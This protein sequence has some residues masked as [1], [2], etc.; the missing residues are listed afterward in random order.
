MSG[1]RRFRRIPVEVQAMRWP[2]STPTT[3]EMRGKVDDIVKWVTG[4]G[5]SITVDFDRTGGVIRRDTSGAGS[6]FGLGDYIVRDPDG[7]FSRWHRPEFRQNY[8]AVPS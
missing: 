8:E 6:R 5:G 4:A 2:S 1:P 3:F 7:R